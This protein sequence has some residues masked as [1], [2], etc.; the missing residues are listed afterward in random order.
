MSPKR[1]RAVTSSTSAPPCASAD[2]NAWSYGGVKAGG[3]ASTTRMRST[4]E[5][6]L[7]RTWN[8]FHGNTKPPGRKAFLEEMVRLASADRPDVLCLQELP[9]WSLEHL[10]RW[11][12]MTAVTDVAKRPLPGTVEL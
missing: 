10:A 6:L 11:S 4:V 8:L 5:R 2:A 12:G 9:V 7:V 3:S 1:K